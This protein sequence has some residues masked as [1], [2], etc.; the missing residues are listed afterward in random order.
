M[1]GRRRDSQ[2][3]PDVNKLL[4]NPHQLLQDTGAVLDRLVQLA[5]RLRC[6]LLRYIRLVHGKRLR[7]SDRFL[8]EP[9]S[10]RHEQAL[11]G[12]HI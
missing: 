10:I 4:D 12:Q 3:D 6:T 7:V 1:L 8:L 5:V 11:L 9:C 2:T